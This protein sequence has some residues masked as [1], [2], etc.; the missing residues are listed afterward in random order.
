MDKPDNTSIEICKEVNYLGTRTLSIHQQDS[1]EW[2]DSRYYTTNR[3]QDDFKYH[4]LLIRA[5]KD[6]NDSSVVITNLKWDIK[7]FKWF[8]W[9]FWHRIDGVTYDVIKCD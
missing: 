5:R 8:S 9:V 4:N 3:P 6:Y 2:D 7:E 1:L